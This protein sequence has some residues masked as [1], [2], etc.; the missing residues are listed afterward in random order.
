MAMV[1]LLVTALFAALSVVAYTMGL[2]WQLL[3]FPVA[4][5]ILLVIMNILR[6]FVMSYSEPVADRPAETAGGES[7]DTELTTAVPRDR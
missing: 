2:E 4:A 5:T 6:R 7:Q 3:R 1:L